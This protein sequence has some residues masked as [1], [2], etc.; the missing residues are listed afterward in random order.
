[1]ARDLT[2]VERPYPPGMI[3][4]PECGTR[5]G[6]NSRG[7]MSRDE[8]L[9]AAGLELFNQRS[10]AIGLQP[11]FRFVDKSDR[12]LALV[13]LGDRQRG[14]PPSTRTPARQRQLRPVT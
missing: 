7:T 11:A 4:I 10:L 8:H 9:R 3:D 14:Q 12:R 5:C 2:G 6:R 13:M 1:M